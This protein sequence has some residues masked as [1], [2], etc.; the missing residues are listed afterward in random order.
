[1]GVRECAACR[2]ASA[3]ADLFRSSSFGG[4]YH[5]TA[6]SGA[7]GFLTRGNEQGACAAARPAVPCVGVGRRG[8]LRVP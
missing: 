4:R 7:E 1:M 8:L 6:S 2:R 5:R 3:P